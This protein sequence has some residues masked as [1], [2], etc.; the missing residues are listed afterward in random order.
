VDASSVL[1][2]VLLALGLALQPWSVL[3]GVMLV[4]SKG[5]V[6]KEFAY[7]TGWVGALLV[8]AALTVAF[9]PAVP[10]TSA[11]STTVAAITVTAG[12]VLGGWLL[13][14]W[15]RPGDGGAKQPAWMARL[16]TMGPAPALVL[17]GFLPNYVLVVAA[18]GDMV[19]AG[20]SQG[21]LVLVALAFVVLASAG[22]AAPLGVLVVRRSQAHQVYDGWRVWLVANSRAVL[23]IVGAVLSVALVA[24]GLSGLL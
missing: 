5:G 14:R 3:A 12:L 9:F 8:V 10:T 7:V 1:T 4:A 16:D 6:R 23:F 15:R 18:V 11:T 24:K 13:V 19:T 22:V 17:G 21:S 2:L 20:L